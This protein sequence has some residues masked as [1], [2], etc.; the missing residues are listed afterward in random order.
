VLENRIADMV[1]PSVDG[2]L[3]QFELLMELVE[4]G[5]WADERDK[6]LIESIKGGLRQLMEG[7]RKTV[8]A[9]NRKTVIPF[10]Y[11]HMKGPDTRDEVQRRGAR[12]DALVRA[13]K[14]LQA[15]ERRA[16]RRYQAAIAESVG[17]WRDTGG[18]A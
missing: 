7:N 14:S 15:Q 6:R 10:P 18:D 11:G 16:L 9:A 17:E 5:G 4:L 13:R 2:V 12:W 8:V 3:A 1:A